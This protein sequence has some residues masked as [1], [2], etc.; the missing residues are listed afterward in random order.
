MFSSKYIGRYALAIVVLGVA[1]YYATKV[2]DA[3]NTNEEHEYKIIKK[4]LLNDSPLYGYNKPKIWIHTKYE[5]NARKWKD[6]Y[7]R[8]TTDLNQPY[9]HLTIK[10]IIDHC[11]DD[12]HI[13]LVDDESFSTLLPTWDISLYTVAEPMRSQL[14]QLGMAQLL[15]HYGGLILPNSFLCLKNMKSFYQDGITGMG[16]SAFV[17]EN[18]NRTCDMSRPYG[19]KELFIP[20]TYIMGAEKNDP[21]I[22]SYVDYLKARS[23]SGHFTN[24]YDFLGDINNWA[25]VNMNEG[26]LQLV[27]GQLVGVKNMKRKQVLIEDLLGE[28]YLDIH[29]NAYGIYIPQDEILKRPKYQWF[30]VLTSEQIFETNAAIVRYIKASIVDTSGLYDA[31]TSEIRS[32]VA[33]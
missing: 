11:G 29:S 19:G 21:T 9:I 26:R 32:V 8:N 5:V 4:F 30:A 23:T 10:S 25:I 24:Q 14:R 27:D 17:T 2:K 28:Q 7:S 13:C 12:F 31:N 16:S 15:Y 6:F 1:T 18:I 20:D 22:K 3:L 33:I